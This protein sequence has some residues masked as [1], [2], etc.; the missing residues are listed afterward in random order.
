M[1]VALVALEYF[2]RGQ[3]VGALAP[4][5]QYVPAGQAVQLPEPAPAYVPA[6][7]G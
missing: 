7:H 3:G 2:S 5:A 1:L 4:A 6:S